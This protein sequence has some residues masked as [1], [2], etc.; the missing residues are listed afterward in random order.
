M[1]LLIVFNYTNDISS[2]SLDQVI[3]DRRTVHIKDN[4]G[5]SRSSDDFEHFS[6]IF[7]ICSSCSNS[8]LSEGD[9]IMQLRYYNEDFTKI[10]ANLTYK[11]YIAGRDY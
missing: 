6:L 5:M 3:D 11:N 1:F 9:D 8:A 4:K 10:K 2:C 7:L